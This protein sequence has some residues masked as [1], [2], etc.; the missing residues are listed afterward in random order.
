MTA[1]MVKVE[2][3]AVTNYTDTF[4]MNMAARWLKFARVSEKSIATY[5]VAIKQMFKYFA[6][7]G[8]SQPTRENLI[9]WIDG[10]IEKKRSANT[11]Q[12]Y[13]VSAKLF[14]RWLA[15]EGIYANIADHLKSGVAPS[16]EHKK[17]ALTVNQGANLLKSIQ[18]DSVKS[19]RDRA[20]IALMLTA[21]LRTIELSRANVGDLIKVGERHYLHVHGKGRND[22]AEKVMVAAQVYNLIKN[23]LATRD[24]ATDDSPLFVSTSR[25]NCGSRLS[26]QTFSKL[27][28][29]YLRVIGLN[30]K[31]YTA[32]SLRHTAAT[33][34]II[35]GVDLT[36]V[37]M[38][39]RHKN[40]TT[41]MIYNNAVERMK[42][43]AEQ[44]AADV[45]FAGI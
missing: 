11:I 13:L 32:H 29:G 42:N 24:D 33:Q 2:K 16:H 4:S 15:D 10:L 23:Y 37:Q 12:L 28:K 38:V 7:N 21:G 39:L 26:T 25:R 44:T 34:M 19:K 20:I 36:Q 3:S 41:T 35:A 31:R 45:F 17:D 9:N 30:S 8:I 1:A 14:F 6:D 40:I 22:K 43:T 5:N 18:G 27:T